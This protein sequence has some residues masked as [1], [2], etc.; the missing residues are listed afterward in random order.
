MLEASLVP[1]FHDCKLKRYTN[2]K[3]HAVD[4]YKDDPVEFCCLELHHRHH[5]EGEDEADAETHRQHQSHLV[6]N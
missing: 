1:I 4:D 3:K 6:A 2:P 5:H